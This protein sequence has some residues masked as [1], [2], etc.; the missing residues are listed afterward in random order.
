VRE[1]AKNRPLVEAIFELRWELE[2][3]QEEG[4]PK[5]KI[6]P[7]YSIFLGR[8]QEQVRDEYPDVERLS[9]DNV[10][11][12][13]S[14]YVLRRRFRKRK[15]WWPLIQVGPGI[16]AVNET[17][18]YNWDSFKCRISDLIDLVFKTYPEPD[19]FSANRLS[20]QYINA[21]EFD[22]NE[23]NILRY[24]SEELGTKIDIGEKI[25]SAA[26]VSRRP[27]NFVLALG[28]PCE[29]P[30]ARL[31]LRISAGTKSG[32]RAVVWEIVV[33]STGENV[34]QE[35]EQICTWSEEAHNVARKWFDAMTGRI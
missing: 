11:E 26:G 12:S 34:P 32:S 4:F 6:D 31:D 14:P 20:L 10:P 16:V 33:S 8:L 29:K 7:N 28:F 25:F 27:D 22:Y 13:M 23:D 18:E 9:A 24:L 30:A 17:E 15:G 1:M 21:K 19:K 5:G 2:E 3:V 35:K